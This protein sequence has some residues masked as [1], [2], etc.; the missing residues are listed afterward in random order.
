MQT[1]PT[2]EYHRGIK[3]AD[4]KTYQKYCEQGS[5]QDFGAQHVMSLSGF[6]IVHGQSV[7]VQ[8]DAAT[9]AGDACTSRRAAPLTRSS[10][11]RT[12]YPF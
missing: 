3:Q 5:A 6:A 7:S 9:G 12:Q 4:G 8:V 1:Y 11:C 2:A 10:S